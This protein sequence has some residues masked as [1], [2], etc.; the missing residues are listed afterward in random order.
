VNA[1]IGYSAKNTIVAGRK[2]GWKVQLN[3]RNLLDE[4]PLK[5]LRANLGGGVLDWGRTE[6][7]QIM[8]ST[9]FTF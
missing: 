5:E 2:I 6:P 7:R 8:L 4:H 1:L 3:I 9:T